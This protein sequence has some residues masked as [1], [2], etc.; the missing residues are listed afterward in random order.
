MAPADEA[1]EAKPSEKR[2]RYRRSLVA[3]A[4][5]V[6]LLIGGAMA[7]LAW[8]GTSFIDQADRLVI[9]YERY[10]RLAAAR[11]GRTLR[12][13]PDLNALDQRLR[14]RGL[15][16]G[17]AVF[18]RI[19]KRNFELELWMRKG[20]SFVRFATYPICG[21]SGRLGPKLKEGDRQAPE[22]FYTVSARQLNPNSRWHRSFNLGFP[23]LHDRR[24]GRTGSFLMVHGGCGSI[25]CY[26]MTDPVITEIWAL[27]TA[28]LKNGQRRF[29]V[30]AYPFRMSARALRLRGG[31]RWSPF[32]RDLKRGSDL[33]ERTRRPPRVQVCRRRYQLSADTGPRL[34]A[35]H[36]IVA[37]CSPT[38]REALL[39]R[40]LVD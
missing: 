35:D 31:H 40:T 1:R 39:T 34:T 20:P 15:K 25:G 3:L 30:H 19:F 16:R 28:A 36:A 17:D 2:G 27:I 4:T 7:V 13:T 14:D 38:R 10:T 6:C 5:A 29:H 22:G 26:A 33:F 8:T 37:R 11:A 12:G 23:N 21:W 18:L 24:H 9:A 32:W